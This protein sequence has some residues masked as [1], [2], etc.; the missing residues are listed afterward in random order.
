MRKRSKG[1]AGATPGTVLTILAAS[2]AACHEPG[3]SR[4]DD[5][6]PSLPEQDVVVIA[7][8]DASRTVA[9]ALGVTRVPRSP[10]RI[11]SLGVAEELV[12]LDEHPVASTLFFGEF[13]D[14]VRPYLHAAQ[15][16]GTAYGA[17]APNIEAVYAARPDLI[18]A[19]IHN[20]RSY[21]QLGD[22]APTVVVVPRRPW[23]DWQ[24]TLEMLHQVARALGKEPRAREIE[25]AFRRK[26]ARARAL[27]HDQAGG[28]SVAT[29]RVLG[30]TLRLNGRPQ[31]GGPILYDLLGLRPPRVIQERHWAAGSRLLFLS[32]E[33]MLDLAVDRLFVIVDSTLGS[34]RTMR[35]ISQREVWRRLPAVQSGYIYPVSTG[36]WQG[37]RLLGQEQVIDDVVSALTGRTLPKLMDQG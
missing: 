36:A 32:E 6:E 8:D 34:A 35:G 24:Y 16:I 9:H 13:R 33:G 29:F 2:L 5:A 1:R 37:G 22:I 14:V 23:H 17:Y 3:S 10:K 31:G 12:L 4:P 20:A 19:S 15:P 25:T 27:L 21:R 26:A 28:E 30:R 7:E 11:A 18:L